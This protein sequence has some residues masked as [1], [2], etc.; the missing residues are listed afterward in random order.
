MDVLLLG[1]DFNSHLVKSWD[2]L[3]VA[4]LDYKTWQFSDWVCKLVPAFDDEPVS[5][6][7]T[8]DHAPLRT[9]ISRNMPC[10]ML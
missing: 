7:E 5:Y 3:K 8:K 2:G 9:P 4:Y 10:L 6:G 1:R